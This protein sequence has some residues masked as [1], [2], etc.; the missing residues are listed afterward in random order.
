MRYLIFVPKPQTKQMGAALLE[1]VG[2]GDHAKGFD[3]M[4]CAA[5]PTGSSG[6]LFG[7]LDPVQNRLVYEPEKQ[8]WIPSLAEGD[9][10]AGA[11][12]VGVW[13]ESKPTETDVRR[14][15]FRKGVWVTMADGTRWQFPSP[16]TLERFPEI[17][18]GKLTWVVDEQFSW[19]VAEIDKRRAML[20]TDETTPGKA[21]VS[22]DLEQDFAFII[23]ALRLNY[24][25]VPEVVV[26]LR[27]ISESTLKALTTG[28]LGYTLI[29]D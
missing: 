2:L 3:T 14:P 23:R 1:S 27:L 9:R 21:F 5:G 22:W 13:N 24:R 10:P 16:S 26:H 11:Y 6:V 17:K 12:W 7:W 15:E 25:L 19:F 20:T 4:Q 28:I 8:T 18:D 29:E